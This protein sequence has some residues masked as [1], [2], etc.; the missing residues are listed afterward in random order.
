MKLSICKK[1]NW[2]KYQQ[3]KVINEKKLILKRM[4]TKRNIKSYFLLKQK[5]IS[6]FPEIKQNF[7]PKQYIKKYI[8]DDVIEVIEENKEN[9]RYTFLNSIRLY[10]SVLRKMQIDVSSKELIELDKF[11][12]VYR[13]FK[14]YVNDILRYYR[15]DREIFFVLKD[16]YNPKDKRLFYN[17]DS[18]KQKIK[19]TYKNRYKYKLHIFLF[20]FSLFFLERLHSYFLNLLKDKKSVKISMYKFKIMAKSFFEITYE[21]EKHLYDES[22]IT[23]EKFADNTKIISDEG[24][25]IISMDEKIVEI[26][27]QYVSYINKI[28]KKNFNLSPDLND[29]TV[30]Y[31][32]AFN[33][34]V[35]YTLA[36]LHH[37]LDLE[38]ISDIFNYPDLRLIGVKLE[39][40]PTN[41]QLN[42]LVLP[43]DEPI[44]GLSAGFKIPKNS[45]FENIIIEIVHKELKNDRD[46]LFLTGYNKFNIIHAETDRSQTVI[47]D[48]L[49]KSRIKGDTPSGFL[50]FLGPDASSKFTSSHYFFITKSIEGLFLFYQTLYYNEG[51][52]I[53]YI[54]KLAHE[55]FYRAENLKK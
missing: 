2:P 8:P 36:Y 42:E 52:T 37:V 3:E 7:N 47:M 44:L 11:Y 24:I 14:G 5:F 34:F 38:K 16:V 49:R 32:V 31:N 25:E 41:T 18:A 12:D 10:K 28:T 9:K 4:I 19:N 48:F 15:E 29:W 53:D 40:N 23:R 27:N 17:I 55:V 54:Y 20:S 6:K 22:S 46:F 45:L 39:Q 33:A 30:L 26:I 50:V 1:L 35:V 21:N 51:K 13:Y 43:N